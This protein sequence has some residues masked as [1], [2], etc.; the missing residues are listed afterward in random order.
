MTREINIARKL[1]SIVLLALGA[2]FICALTAS[3]QIRPLNLAGTGTWTL[4]PGSCGFPA[5]ATG[6]T[7]QCLTVDDTVTG[8]PQAQGFEKG[9][10]SF[11]ISI[12]TSVP[13]LPISKAGNCFP[14]GGDAQLNDPQRQNFVFFQVS[15]FLCPVS[16][17]VVQVFNGSYWMSG[18]GGSASFSG[19]TGQVSLSLS[20]TG[21][22][23]RSSINGYLQK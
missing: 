9:S 13:K 8:V 2:T 5:C 4:T 14:A 18:T 12:D 3:A 20:G 10:L 22:S 6:D 7:C 11:T 1:S 19:G 15:G 16:I 21:T 17:G 23:G